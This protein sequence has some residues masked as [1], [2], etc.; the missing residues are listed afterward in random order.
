LGARN[1]SNIAVATTLS[2][3]IVSGDTSLV[4]VSATGYP[5]APFTIVIERT[6]ANEEVILV[7][8][9]SGT[10]FSSLTRAFDGTSAFGHAAGVPIELVGVAQDLR[11][12]TDFRSQ[13]KRGTD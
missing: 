5:A 3:T 4:V 6:T 7:G 10:T 2:V 9:K 11:D 1:Y 12:G 13:A 8:A